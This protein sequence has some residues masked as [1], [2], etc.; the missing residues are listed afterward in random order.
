MGTKRAVHFVIH[1]NEASRLVK[2]SDNDFSSSD[3]VEV[4][5]RRA[6]KNSTWREDF[7]LPMASAEDLSPKEF[8]L[9]AHQSPSPAR[10][11]F[12]P[13]TLSYTNRYPRNMSWNQGR[14]QREDGLAAEATT[15][16]K[17]KVTSFGNSC[18]STSSRRR[19]SDIADLDLI[20]SDA[21]KASAATWTNG[22]AACRTHLVG[23]VGISNPPVLATDVGAEGLGDLQ[24]NRQPREMKGQ[25]E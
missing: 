13:T 19:T 17:S 21:A 15:L 16:D 12:A 25:G 6:R 4:R 7:N 2:T 14:L 10:G 18:I 24:S 9:Q 1:Q 8:K 5:K 3:A 23:I 22:E 20:T 11:R